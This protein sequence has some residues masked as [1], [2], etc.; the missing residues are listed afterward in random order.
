M[1][2]NVNT[3][4]I[5]IYDSN[6]IGTGNLIGVYSGG[7]IPPPTVS[8]TGVMSI[9]FISN[10]WLPRSGFVVSYEL[11]NKLKFFIIYYIL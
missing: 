4:F 7:T 2:T 1:D 9:Q 8:T 10:S 6:N 11:S 3:D 5:Y